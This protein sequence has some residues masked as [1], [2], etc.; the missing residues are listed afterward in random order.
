MCRKLKRIND[1]SLKRFKVMDENA[2]PEKRMKL[3]KKIRK[4]IACIEHVF[5]RDSAVTI[6]YNGVVQ[7]GEP[8]SND[9][10][11][12]AWESFT[13]EA[14]KHGFELKG[15]EWRDPSDMLIVYASV[16]GGIMFGPVYKGGDGRSEDFWNA[17]SR[18]APLNKVE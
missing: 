12:K 15:I 1:T 8:R 14:Q 13:E 3:T 10:A 6:H 4:D 18:N 7:H 16:T 17:L 11:K 2:K 9:I 5:S